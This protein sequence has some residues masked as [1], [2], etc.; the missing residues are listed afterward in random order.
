MLVTSF[1]RCIGSNIFCTF[2]ILYIY[3]EDGQM[4]KPK[5]VGYSRF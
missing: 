5:H 2:H 1:S 3:P 4:S